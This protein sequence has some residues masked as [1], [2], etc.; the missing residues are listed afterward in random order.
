ML[1]SAAMP[2]SSLGDAPMTHAAHGHT[3]AMPEHHAAMSHDELSNDKAYCPDTNHPCCMAATI[4]PATLIPST[5][6]TSEV[7]L[8]SLA[9]SMPIR[10][11][12]AIYKPPKIDSVLIG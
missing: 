4:M 2:I 6:F 5:R 7:L 11:L 9:L 8:P 3:H 10:R 1:H 12:N